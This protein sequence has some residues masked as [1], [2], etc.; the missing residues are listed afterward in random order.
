MISTVRLP[1][2]VVSCEVCDVQMAFCNCATHVVKHRN[3]IELS[4]F[5]AKLYYDS[6][7]AVTLVQCDAMVPWSDYSAHVAQ[8]DRSKQ[9][10][11]SESCDYD[12]GEF[13]TLVRCDA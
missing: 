9:L 5:P 12:C 13:L 8:K 3:Y 2:T 11:V 10:P 6:G 1:A 4:R 7:E